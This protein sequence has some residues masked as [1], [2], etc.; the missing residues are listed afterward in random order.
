MKTFFIE[1]LGCAL[2]ELDAGKIV[3]W[4]TANGLSRTASPDRAGHVFFVICGLNDERVQ[5]GIRRILAF[6]QLSGELVVV[7]CLPIMHPTL[8][9]SVFQGKTVVTKNINALDELFPEFAIKFRDT[10]DANKSIVS[11]S[12]NAR[13]IIRRMSLPTIMKKSCETSLE[14]CQAVL[15][16]RPLRNVEGLVGGIGFDNKY[17]S[18]RISDGCAWKCGYCSMKNAIGNVRSKPTR[19]ILDEARKGVDSGAFQFNIVSSDSGSYG[20][21]IGTTLPQL[22]AAVLDVDPRITIEFVQDL[23]PFFL[24]KFR[25]ELVALIGTGRIKSTQVPFQSGSERVLKAMKRHLDFNQYKETVQ[26]IRRVNPAFKI[27]TQVIIGYPTETEED[28]LKTLEVLRRCAFDEVDVFAYYENEGTASQALYP[29]VPTPVLI[30]RMNQT[31]EFLRG[32]P[33]RFVA[34]YKEELRHGDSQVCS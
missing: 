31:R 15:H 22:L 3:N 1:V 24:C 25:K 2:R 18:L 17:F 11:T 7:G 20:M 16:R 33:V 28:Y 23:N 19:Q 30:E 6:K 5:D 29:K 21:D 34:N 27:R 10:P 14:M 8:F 4:L 9:N 32:T 26:E 12:V 13:Q